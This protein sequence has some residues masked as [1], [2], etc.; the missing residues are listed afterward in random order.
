LHAG[1]QRFRRQRAD[2]GV[3][4]RLNVFPLPRNLMPHAL[5]RRADRHALSGMRQSAAF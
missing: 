1:K 3:L 4:E 2:T 5:D